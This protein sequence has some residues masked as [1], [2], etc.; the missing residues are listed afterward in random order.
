MALVD[1]IDK[2]AEWKDIPMPNPGL[3]LSLSLD[4][5]KQR[6]PV[7]LNDSEGPWDAEAPS[8]G[9]HLHTVYG[10]RWYQAV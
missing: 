3:N 10:Y 6:F 1:K 2:A 9:C 7:M 5:G 8:G 4:V